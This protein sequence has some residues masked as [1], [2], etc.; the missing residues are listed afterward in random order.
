MSSA[1][2][3]ENSLLTINNFS[4]LDFGPCQHCTP[5]ISPTTLSEVACL[6]ECVILHNRCVNVGVP[7]PQNALRHYKVVELRWG[8]TTV[9]NSPTDGTSAALAAAG[10]A[11]SH[12]AAAHMGTLA[13]FTHQRGINAQAA[14]GCFLSD[15]TVR[16]ITRW[17]RDHVFLLG[18]FFFLD[19]RYSTSCI[20]P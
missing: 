19:R 12:R 16:E 20:F 13:C 2:N 9:P 7:P 11:A 8:T 5:S 15:N 3:H 14:F 10:P 1:R 17:Q 6:F 18:D 4:T